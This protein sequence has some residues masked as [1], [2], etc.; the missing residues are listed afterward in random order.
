MD[1]LENILSD[2]P[3]AEPIVEQNEVAQPPE[4]PAQPRDE[5]GRFAPK[6]EKEGAPPAPVDK[7]PEF[8]HQA[9]IGER[10]RRQEA[11]ARLAELEQRFS[12]M[13]NPPPPAPDM[14]ESPE[15]WQGH[16][17]QEVTRD[18]VDQASLMSKL[19]TSEMLMHQNH[20]DFEDVQAHFADL[21]KSN[22]GLREEVV[23]HRHPWKKAYEIAKSDLAMKELGAVNVSDLEAKL[24]EKITA[25][26]TA[27]APVSPNIPV[28]LADAQSAR[29]GSQVVPPRRSLEDILGVKSP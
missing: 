7:E 2:E 22:P 19:Q 13:Q 24:R 8:D 10:R 29:G 23:N 12:A 14:F 17:K 25:E 26:L 4:E 6:G 18:A 1:S 9:V 21:L 5:S 16:V 27:Q 11:E 15:E 28:S 3:V 20:D